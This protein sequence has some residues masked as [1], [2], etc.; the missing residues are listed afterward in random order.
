LLITVQLKNA[1]AI[2]L[3]VSFPKLT[4]VHERKAWVSK[5]LALMGPGVLGIWQKIPKETFKI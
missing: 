5:G 1:L 2:S 4:S 3:D